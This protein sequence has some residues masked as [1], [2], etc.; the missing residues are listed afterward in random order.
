MK[1]SFVVILS[2]CAWCVAS[3]N[4]FTSC[5]SQPNNPKGT[6]YYEADDVTNIMNP[7]RGFY[8]Y[9]DI[10]MDGK[11]NGGLTNDQA[12][13]EACEA[14]GISLVFRY[15]YLDHYNDGT[16][17][18]QADLELINNDFAVIRNNGKKVIARFSYGARGYHNDDDWSFVE[19]TKEQMLAHMAQLK[20]VLA[21]N[22]DVIAVVQAGFAGIWGE[23]YFSSTFGKD[24]TKPGAV[25]D[26]NDLINGLLDMAPVDRFV[27]LRTVHYITE[28][29]GNGE[30]D[31]NTLL[32]D[33]T[34][35]LG[36]PQS[37]LGLHNDAYCHDI[38]NC[39]TYYDYEP[40]R[41][42]LAHLG[43]YAPL[44][45]ETNGGDVNFY[46]G[47][48]AM[49]DMQLLHFDYM[50]S[51]FHMRVLNSWK[52]NKPEGSELSYYE[53]MSNRLGYRL[54][55]E[56]FYAPAVVSKGELP[57]IFSVYNDGFSN[58]YNK[59]IAYIVLK[60]ETNTYALPI[61][62]DPRLWKSA[63]ATRV[64]E[65]LT[66]PDNAA[67]GTYKVY[68]ALPDVYE[69]IANNP[70]YAIRLANKDMKWEDGLNDLGLTIEIH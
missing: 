53:I 22:A 11:G 44:G 5:Q 46:N 32:T 33:E 23:W 54:R 30:R 18:S 20:P 69:S 17:I 27:Q 55:L 16:P 34:A 38:T 29:M 36:T 26:R 57:I 6:V 51:N 61:Q 40:E 49:A 31:Y 66:L 63:T 21:A 13:T 24:W 10:V 70:A 47:A 68:F 67:E 56:S 62:S 19:P 7:E 8:H 58:L 60:N 12:L 2:L 43:Q 65:Y 45:G 39:G 41:R 42:Y 50:N 59:R 9:T 52:E 37:R 25:A 14:S 48:A 28:Y 3:G 4:L 64:E 15:F 1:K 35:F